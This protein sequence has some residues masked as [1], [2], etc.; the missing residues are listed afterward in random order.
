MAYSFFAVFEN[1]VLHTSAPPVEAREKAARSLAD[2]A[3]SSDAGPTRTV[4]VD[5]A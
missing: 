4:T 5:A 1:D 2:H 3:A